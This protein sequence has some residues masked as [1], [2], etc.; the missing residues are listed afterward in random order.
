MAA[1]AIWTWMYSI[2]HLGLNCFGVTGN[3]RF[4]STDSTCFHPSLSLFLST[5]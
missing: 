4:I 3:E 1:V 2:V 5:V